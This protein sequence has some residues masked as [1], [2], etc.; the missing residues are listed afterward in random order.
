[1][2]KVTPS[3]DGAESFRR[4]VEWIRDAVLRDEDLV[5]GLAS[6]REMG[7]PAEHVVAQALEIREI[8]ILRC[9]W[10]FVEVLAESEGVVL[11]PIFDEVMGE[12]LCQRV[13]F[14]LLGS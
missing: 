1:M 14:A 8:E 12:D 5:L 10:E 4:S 6:L 3:A 11:G 13:R 7:P 9:S 2:A